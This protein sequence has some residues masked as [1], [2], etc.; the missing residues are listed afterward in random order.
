MSD[1][2]TLRGYR[3]EFV[4]IEVRAG[5]VTRDDVE[6]RLIVGA[7]VPFDEPTPIRDAEGEYL[8]VFRR[9]A[10][11]Q[12]INRGVE[13]IKLLV[14]HDRGQLA[15]GRADLLREDPTVLYGE[16]FVPR[17]QAGDEAI[18]L[19]R[20]GVADAFSVGFQ[21]LDSGTRWNEDRTFAERLEVAMRE[22]SLVNWGAYE[23]ARISGVRQWMP[24]TISTPDPTVAAPEKGP[25]VR[26]ADEEMPD[27][28]DAAQEPVERVAAPRNRELLRL[29]ARWIAL[30]R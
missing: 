28:D 21:P 4:D 29:R 6:G 12:S 30:N 13:R 16:F 1:E 23:G 25:G 9:G 19:V 20:G 26:S 10:F 17:T 14:N 15:I 8:E 2:I 7:V 5:V 11:K 3:S 18:E 24:A 22:A 27:P